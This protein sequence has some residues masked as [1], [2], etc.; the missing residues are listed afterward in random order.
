MTKILSPRHP[1]VH[2][3]GFRA[4]GEGGVEEELGKAEGSRGSSQPCGLRQGEPGFCA[5]GLRNPL[6]STKGGQV[7]HSCL[8]MGVLRRLLMF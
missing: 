5:L 4:Q 2:T 8:H 3:R 7:S 6:W 1:Q